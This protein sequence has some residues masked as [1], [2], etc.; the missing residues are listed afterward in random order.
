[1]K[2]V[3]LF[4][5]ATT[6]CAIG[7]EQSVAQTPANAGAG[8]PLTPAPISADPVGSKN[9][10]GQPDLG[11]F[12][13]NVT[14]TPL[15]RDP[16]FGDKAALTREE[17]RS[18]EQTFAAALEARDSI[19]SDT[20]SLPGNAEDKAKD[21]QLIAARGD[22]A[23]SG[24]DVGG[25]NTYWLDPG[26]QMLEI[27]GEYRTS[28]LTTPNGLFPPPKAH[29]QKPAGSG[30]QVAGIASDKY[31]SYEVRPLNDRCISFA[32]NA[33]PPMLPNGYYNNNYQIVQTAEHVMIEIEHI[34]D[35][36]IVRLNGVHRKD[37]LRPWNGD[38]IGRYEGN[39]LVVE[40]IN[41]PE[42]QNFLGSWRNLKVT[43]W[44]T[45]ISPGKILYR[46]EVEDPEMWDR[47]WGG[48]YTFQP[49]AGV[50]YEYACHEGNYAM[51]SILSGARDLEKRGETP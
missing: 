24:G 12:W 30:G 28:I 2:R 40:T 27:N 51:T 37:G 33:P 6:L 13:T 5:A 21:A 23:E 15:T 38:S 49:L 20:N 9:V 34:H 29:P 43:E 50:V 42:A 4:L 19:V 47:S 46:F 48:E 35:V 25:Y 10:F 8:A 44:F 39:S 16:R 31:D 36:R 3:I 1:M 32:R 17:A 18:R 14:L 11:G 7:S 41:L 22:F 45:R 26:T